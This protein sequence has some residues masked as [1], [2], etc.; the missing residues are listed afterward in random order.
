MFGGHE[1]TSRHVLM[2]SVHNFTV[3][4]GRRPINE[5][6]VVALMESVKAIGVQ[7]PITYRV[8]GDDYEYVVVTGAHRL[9]ACKRLDLECIPSFE[10]FGTEAEAGL[11]EIDENLHRADLTRDER[12]ALIVKRLDIATKVEEEQKA[13]RDQAARERDADRKR[14]KRSG[15]SPHGAEEPRTGGRP[16]GGAED[17]ARTMGVSGDTVRRAE[18]LAKLT[19][20][21]KA[22]AQMYHLPQAVQLDAVEAG[23]AQ[24]QMA[25]LQRAYE[26]RV[27][28]Q[29]RRRSTPRQDREEQGQVEYCMHQWLGLRMEIERLPEALV[30]RVLAQVQE[31]IESVVANY[32]EALEGQ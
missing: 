22:F 11:W 6:T 21:A 7:V 18:K 31:D 17:T 14:R 9:E 8:V 32:D 3:P 23:D 15:D 10:F 30:R 27:S 4:D 5:E 25:H 29:A 16:K 28:A 1:K 26:A 20:E 2:T 12:D 13:R 19:P 24:A